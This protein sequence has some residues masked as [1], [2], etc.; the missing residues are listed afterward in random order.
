MATK[1]FD[2]EIPDGQHLG[3]SRD[4]DGAYRA[5][6][7]D[8][9]TN[10]LVGHAELFEHDTDEAQTPR[11]EYVY[12]SD[13][14]P[15]RG[16]DLTD[17]EL[18]ETIEALLNLG[19]VA[20]MLAIKAAPHV[21]G[22]W[23]GTAMPALK[24][25]GGSARSAVKLANEKTV[26]SIRSKSDTALLT[27]KSAWPKLHKDP[28]AENTVLTGQTVAAGSEN[29]RR[30]AQLETAFTEYRSRMGSA[31]ARE[32]FVATLVARA[33]SDQ[34]MQALRDATIEDNGDF[35]GLGDAMKAL[36]PQRVGET[37]SL[38]LEKNPSLLEP[39]SILELR[40]IFGGGNE[41]LALRIER[42]Q[43]AE[44]L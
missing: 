25:A 13:S 2:V 12:V 8:D 41:G 14:E 27:L 21:A 16:H 22:W 1:I 36:T 11:V 4:T 31:E 37:I 10:G 39:Q 38:M 23:R 40:A 7:F 18:E 34:Q 9:E 17:K 15:S 26:R 20:A 6:L 44:T 43:T 32:R 24:S 19:I 33:F 42:P 35:P 28:K 3:F 29:P 5:H 30:P